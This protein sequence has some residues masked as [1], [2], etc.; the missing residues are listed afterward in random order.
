MSSPHV[1]EVS[2]QISL[3]SPYVSEVSS[4]IS[5]P[6]PHLSEVSSQISLSSPHVSEVSSQISLSSPHVSEVSSQISMSSPHVSEMSQIRLSSPHRCHWLKLFYFRR[7]HGPVSTMFRN[8]P[9]AEASFVPGHHVFH[10]PRYVSSKACARIRDLPYPMCD[11][12]Q[13]V[14]EGGVSKLDD[15]QRIKVEH[16]LERALAVADG[17]V[18]TLRRLREEH[19]RR[20]SRGKALHH[21]DWWVVGFTV[22]DLFSHDCAY[23]QGNITAVRCLHTNYRIF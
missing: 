8:L 10:V 4:Q 9:E 21:D 16:T 15:N 17:H 22:E 13:M 1:S 12:E 11:L 7:D 20:L 14:P 18:L 5:L 19:T 6:S 2:S 3:S 23:V